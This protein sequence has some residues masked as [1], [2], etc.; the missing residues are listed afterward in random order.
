[1]HF[2]TLGQVKEE[3]LN[4]AEALGSRTLKLFVLRSYVFAVF[5]RT[6]IKVMSSV[7]CFVLFCKGVRSQ[8]TVTQPASVSV[9]LGQTVTLSCSRSSA[10]SWS[11]YFCWQQQIDGHRPCHVQC[12][13]YSRGEGIPDRFTA[14]ASGTNGYLAITNVQPEDE[15][16]YYC[17]TWYGNTF[18]SGAV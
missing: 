11:S 3:R 10:G 9:S 14:S 13:G 4:F 16:D 8:P 7:S 18:H 5:D 2:S 15:A 17:G 1:M 6:V 12:S